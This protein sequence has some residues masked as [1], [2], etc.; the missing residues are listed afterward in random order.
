[1]IMHSV[2][3]SVRWPANV[4]HYSQQG[5][6]GQTLVLCLDHRVLSS[7]EPS[8]PNFSESPSHVKE[9]LL[10]QALDQD[11]TPERYYLSSRLCRRALRTI[12]EG[13][14]NPHPALIQALKENSIDT[15][16]TPFLTPPER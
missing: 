8:T 14:K 13:R 3:F 11:S 12:T 2:I 4:A 16:L 5:N 7:G 9:C 10:W 6:G 1:M 15:V